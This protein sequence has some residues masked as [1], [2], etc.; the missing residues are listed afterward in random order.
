VK[1]GLP[2]ELTHMDWMPDLMENLNQIV[3][4]MYWVHRG[5]GEGPQPLFL[6]GDSCYPFKK[7]V[8]SSLALLSHVDA[9][10][11]PRIVNLDGYLMCPNFLALSD[12]VT[13]NKERIGQH[14]DLPIISPV[15]EVHC[16]KHLEILIRD[17]VRD[18][19]REVTVCETKPVCKKSPSATSKQYRDLSDTIVLIGH[20]YVLSDSKLNNGVPE[21]LQ[22]NNF[23]TITAR[24]IPFQKLD[25]L[26][27]YCDYYAK[28]LYWRSAREALGAFLYFTQVQRPAGII[29]MIP[30]NCGVDALLRIELQSLYN[31]MENV[32]PFM[33]LVCDEHTQRDHLVTRIEAFLDIIHGIRII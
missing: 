19:S 33:A 8:W 9:L 2:E 7:M 20:P 6:D 25:R 18:L 27:G 22:A 21:I 23:T 17:I 13:I 4:D 1:I 12:I 3:P 31:R 14:N 15:M 10:L 29:H 24:E 30:F 11:L 28:K 32:T 16:I 5:S 26:A